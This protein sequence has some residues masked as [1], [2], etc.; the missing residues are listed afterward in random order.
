MNYGYNKFYDTGPG[1]YPKGEQLKGSSF[2]YKDLIRMERLA[3][4]KR[5]S[6]FCLFV[7]D[8]EIFLI[9]LTEGVYVT[10]IFSS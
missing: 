5:S 10:A 2:N 1:A 4:D 9:T 3:R 8:E 6:L 7:N